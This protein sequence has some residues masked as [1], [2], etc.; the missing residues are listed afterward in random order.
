MEMISFRKYFTLIRHETQS[1]FETWTEEPM[2]AIAS[3]TRIAIFFSPAD[4]FLT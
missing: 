1:R 4:N 2:H 3:G